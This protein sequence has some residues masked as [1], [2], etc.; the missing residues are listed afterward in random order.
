MKLSLTANRKITGTLRGLKKNYFRVGL[1][2]LIVFYLI[3]GVAYLRAQSI[4]SDEPS[5]WNYANRFLKGHPDRIYP[6]T[7]NSKMPI[8][9]LN[10]IPRIIEQMSHPGLHKSDWGTADIFEGRY[11]TLMVT[12]GTIMLVFAW[13]LQLYGNKAALFAAFLTV[14]CP[15]SLANA[16][17]VT[18]DSYSAL[19]LLLSIYF[20]WKFCKFKRQKYFL[21]LS[22]VVALSQL[23]KQSLFHLYVLI[24]I[25]LTIFYFVERPAIRLRS[26]LINL[27]IF[28]FINWFIINMGYYFYGTNTALGE[29]H[30]MSNLFQS[31]QNVFPSHFIVPLPKPFVDGLDMAK[32]YD[33]LGGGYDEISSF[34]KVT[35]LEKEATG[36]GFWYYYFVS[37]LF[38]TPL[39]YLVLVACSIVFLLRKSTIAGFIRNEFFLLFPVVYFLV[40]MSFLYKTQC[41]IR[42]IIF[43]FPFLF[44]LS[45]SLIPYARAFLSKAVVAFLSVYLVATVLMYWRNYYPYTNELIIDKK[46][47]YS[48]VGASNLEFSQGKFFFDDYL[49]HH[50]GVR[51]ITRM[52]QT[53][54]FLL[55][56]ADYLDIWNR[57]WYEWIRPIKPA[58]QVAYNGLL[59]TVTADG[60]KK[61]QK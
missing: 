23:V 47:A 41:G 22:L 48:Y 2:V 60:L 37:I 17:L 46:M 27:L 53:G 57:G 3:N 61:I 1:A 52:P 55:N 21:L 29:Y 44:I 12:I 59:I 58:G 7:D 50:P 19:F 32:Y 33:Q 42:H 49:Q 13:A 16:A 4:T 43:I 11:V 9:V 25:A 26:C 54:T 8:I 15:N 30:F 31:V 6:A 36:A 20:L 10:L 56:S 45:S 38:K 5:F 18:T 35:I 14:F 39:T 40:L 34:G 24:P 28:L 51:R